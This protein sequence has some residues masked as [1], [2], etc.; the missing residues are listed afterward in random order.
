MT[1]ASGANDNFNSSNDE[2]NQALQDYKD[3]TDT[4]EYYEQI[5]DSLFDFDSSVFLQI[6]PTMTLFSSCITAI[7]TKLGDLSVPLT[8]FLIMA[9]ISVIIG[10]ARNLSGGD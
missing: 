8:M 2:V 9:A 10:I 7:W 5:D 6:A 3:Q 1:D 4:S